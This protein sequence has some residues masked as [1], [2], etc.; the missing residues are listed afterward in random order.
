MVSALARL[1]IAE[2]AAGRWDAARAAAGE[3]VE[4][5]RGVGQTALTAFP[6][7]WLALLA[8]LRGD[9]SAVPTL[10]QVQDLAS[11][12]PLGVLTGPVAD[13]V[14]WTRTVLS[15]QAHDTDAALLA[16]RRIAHPIFHHLAA[17]DR[18]EAA[19][20]AD[21][22][23]LARSWAETLAV[24]GTAVDAPAVSAAAEYGFALAADADTAE[25]DFLAA[26]DLHARGGRPVDTARTRLAYGELLR[27][28]GRRVDARAH[29][30]AALEVFDDVGARPWAERARQE[31]RA[32]GETA[33]KRDVSTVEDLTPQELQTARLVTQG[34]SNREVAERMY[35]SPRTVEY[36]L[37]HV[38][39]KLGVR[40]RGELG[41]VAL[42]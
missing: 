14:A 21:E 15:A 12:Q 32:S 3:A 36:H 19:V 22:R 23:G 11:T 31:L 4:L 5:A 26:I 9:E 39:Q 24:F 13:V 37:S 41:Q 2:V 17:A 1:P 7:A 10:A 42:G 27:R 25:Q 38:Y 33:R 16:A 40:S 30:R 35:V 29:L 18:L 8:A 6:L 20:R 34:L 28:N